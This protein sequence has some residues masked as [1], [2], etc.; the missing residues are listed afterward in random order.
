MRRVEREI[1][2]FRPQERAYAVEGATIPLTLPFLDDPVFFLNNNDPSKLGH[3]L[4]KMAHTYIYF[5]NYDRTSD[6]SQNYSARPSNAVYDAVQRLMLYTEFGP[7]R[8]HPAEMDMMT[9]DEPTKSIGLALCSFNV[10]VPYSR[11]LGIENPVSRTRYVFDIAQFQ[12][13]KFANESEMDHYLG[14]LKYSELFVHI[15]EQLAWRMANVRNVR[16]QYVSIQS[17]MQYDSSRASRNVRQQKERRGIKYPPVLDEERSGQLA[18]IVEK[19]R[20]WAEGLGYN[21]NMLVRFG[22]WQRHDSLAKPVKDI[23]PDINL[24]NHLGRLSAI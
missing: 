12:T 19:R 16:V 15:I 3:N 8:V 4:R 11:V 9:E 24:Q 18:R 17:Q 10:G 23:K 21:T 20:R 22:R 6:E 1:S 2:R 5:W 7:P 13:A 14:Y